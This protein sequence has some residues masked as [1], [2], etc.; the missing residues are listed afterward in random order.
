MSY[1]VAQLK[2]SSFIALGAAVTLAAM[3]VSALP[4][5]AA[6]HRDS[7]A[8]TGYTIT[9]FA[10]VGNETKPDDLTRLGNSVY[11][12]FQNGVGSLGE[13]A[14]TGVTS[15]TIQQYSLGG[16]P[17]RSFQVPGKIDGLTAD[18]AHHRL[19]MTTNEDGNSHFSTLTIGTRPTLKTYTYS[20]LTHGGGTDAISVVHGRI[21]VSAS[22]PTNAS[23]PALYAVALGGTTATLTPEFADDSSVTAVNGPQAGK[24][25]VLGLSDP[26]S[27][28]VVPRSSPRYAG[29][30]MLTAQADQQLIF[31]S[32]LGTDK[33]ELQ[34]LSV[35]QPL[36]DTA[37]ATRSAQTLWVTDPSRNTV[38]AVT[39][40]F[41]P[42]EAISAVTPDAG[43]AYLA[44]LN[45]ADGTLTPIQK[46]SAIQP[47]GL[48]FSP[49]ADEPETAQ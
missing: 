36:D 42:G 19:L 38:H 10:P 16:H 27:N 30:F 15:S 12:A 4:A 2:R 47:K 46:L 44:T 31:A 48:L 25:V 24:P 18:N 6:E 7:N 45:L 1:T 11:V 3:G 20:G 29:E 8:A 41:T 39:G 22:A 21:L 43:P 35:S 26:D 37:F 5:S 34:A 23:G 28:T 33:Q 9:S 17:G 14:T 13:P 32:H 40:P 49:T